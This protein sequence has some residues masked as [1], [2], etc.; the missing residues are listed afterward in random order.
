MQLTVLGTLALD[1]RPVPGARVGAL[2]RTLAAAR[3][4]VV[5]TT[6]LVEDVWDG[7]PPADATGAL[8]ALVSRARRLGLRVV[9]A[10]DGYR[11]DLTDLQVDSHEVADLLARARTALRSGQ[12]AAAVADLTAARALLP[13]APS[14]TDL[15]PEH[16]RRLADVVALL[17]EAQLAAGDV[18]TDLDDLRALALGDL[19]DEPLVALLVRALAAQGREAEALE[20]VERL[21][22]DLAER[23]GTDPSPVV[24]AA[25]LALLRGEL[26][27]EVPT[28]DLRAPAPTAAPPAREPAPERAPTSDV[29]PS[30]TWRRASSPLVGRDE[31]VAAVQDALARQQL[32]TLVATG[33]A[34]KTRLAV[35]VAQR[36]AA[37]GSDVHVVELA[38]LRS[39]EEVLPALLGAVGA[40]E[41]VVDLDRMQ[42]RRLLSPDDRLRLLA[43]ELQGLL[44]LDNCEHLLDATADLV[45]RLLGSAGPGL[46]VLTTSRAPLGVPGEAVH[47]VHPLTGDDAVRLLHERASTVRPGLA[48][49]DETAR[50]LVARLDHLPLAIELAAARLRSMPLVEVLAGVDD[51]FGLLDHALRGLPE[52]HA[53][54]WAMVDWSWDLLAAPEREALR[55][56]SVVPAPFTAT[57]G[58]AVIGRA[59][60]RRI[61]STLVD[62]SLLVLEEDEEGQA[63]YR[64]LETVREYGEARLDQEGDRDAAL[65]RLVGWAVEEC[66]D[67]G[68]MFGRRQV[69]SLRRTDLDQEILVVAMQHALRRDA[70]GPD[71][72][73][74]AVTI[75]AVLLV[76]WTVRGLHREA[77]TT[78][79]ALLF[80]SDPARRARL[81]VS[82]VRG[83]DGPRS[84]DRLAS[85]CLLAGLNASIVGDLRVVAVARRLGRRLL[86]EADRARGA[87][88]PQIE[89]PLR[90][91]P[92]LDTGDPSDRSLAAQGAA[93]QHLMAQSDPHLQ[94]LGLM[95]RGSVQENVG[96]STQ[97]A[98]DMRAAYALFAEVEDHWGMGMAA[99]ALGRHAPVDPHDVETWLG[100][101]EEHLTLVGALEDARSAGAM[102]DVRRAV[103]GVEGARATLEVTA[104]TSLEPVL[105]AHAELGLA[106]LAAG[107]SRWPEAVAHAE[108][109][110][111]AAARSDANG[112]VHSRVLLEVVAAIMRLHS[113]GDA[114]GLLRS[115][116]ALALPLHDAPLLASV[117]L[118]LAAV[119]ARE[120]DRETAR[121]LWAL[122]TRL[123]PNLS[124][125][126]T[127]PLTSTLLDLDTV[128]DPAGQAL[129]DEARTTS[130]G[131]T[132]ARLTALLTSLLD[133]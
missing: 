114:P 23:Y 84:L 59:D 109:A 89:V 61:L 99:A 108:R 29:R 93:A 73:D 132:L 95:L 63:R 75:S 78:A 35:E 129:L 44:V 81:I 86:D 117:G 121:T 116:L 6:G 41:S 94:A 45:A 79:S 96:D 13:V 19:P 58:A 24:A 18:P 56:L 122:S 21:R 46:T 12:A 119:R 100:R 5:T 104:A 32:V 69:D 106:A 65:D 68:R 48:W 1:G 42:G 71:G 72:T 112:Q 14:R 90:L 33:G 31:D 49:D 123:G 2:V 126:L 120:G 131:E 127:E 101:A 25:H 30:T 113:G 88:S 11:L 28:P 102:R 64:M 40:A 107:A 115:A 92:S 83:Q 39:A 80:C 97:G 8:Q 60:A 133:A 34:G 9:A 53:G 47:A 66:R 27:H 111:G 82:H 125:F 43:S 50:A 54:L 57:A 7:E 37:R 16:A 130:G 36:A 110:V 91:M 4:R 26:G 22:T 52:R 98:H 85:V 128:A 15:D 124:M 20:T 70:P 38:G 3:G 62:Q 118:G 105:R 17:V 77:A 74:A 76:W 51:R 10:P 87:M 67:L 103:R 55:D